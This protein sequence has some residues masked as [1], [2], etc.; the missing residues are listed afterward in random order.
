VQ[1]FVQ[2][3]AW[4]SERSSQKQM[5]PSAGD[6][7]PQAIRRVGGSMRSVCRRRRRARRLGSHRARLACARKVGQK[8]LLSRQPAHLRDARLRLGQIASH[9]RPIS[10]GRPK[11]ATTNP[12]S[13]RIQPESPFM[14][15]GITAKTGPTSPHIFGHF[16]PE[17]D[18]SNRAS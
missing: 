10:Q 13:F 16:H 7:R 14:S 11:R 3:L 8:P 5:R 2:C 9:T 4:R 1:A 17:G 6:R 15:G 18:E 12:K